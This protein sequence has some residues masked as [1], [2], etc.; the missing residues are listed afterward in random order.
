MDWAIKNKLDA[1]ERNKWETKQAQSEQ[2]ALSSQ[3][4]SHMLFNCLNSIRELIHLKKNDE[5]EEYLVKFSVFVRGVLENSERRN[6]TLEKELEVSESYLALEALSFEDSFSYTIEVDENIDTSFIGLPPLILQP[7]IENALIHGLGPKEGEKWI[8]IEVAE[9]EG[10][11][12]CTIEDN[13]VGIQSKP[14]IKPTLANPKQS[15]GR[16][17]SEERITVFNKIYDS[18]IS[19]KTINKKDQEGKPNGTIIEFLIDY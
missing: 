9:L 10:Q 4:N 13:G 1:Q 6:S 5:A 19:V 11:V 12:R 7:Y 3:L 8:K 2:K 16:K 15:L 17:L 18:Q 14:V